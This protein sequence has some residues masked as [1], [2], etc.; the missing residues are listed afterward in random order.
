MKAIFIFLLLISSA[1]FAQSDGSGIKSH[2]YIEVYCIIKTSTS[3]YPKYEEAV[4]YYEGQTQFEVVLSLSNENGIT[5]IVLPEDFERHIILELKKKDDLKTP[6]ENLEIMDKGIVNKYKYK[7][8]ADYDR[9]NFKVLEP[10]TGMR[11]SLIGKLNNNRPLESGLY[12]LRCEFKEGSL[13]H[14]KSGYG[15]HRF[16]IV[17]PEMKDDL[18]A[19]YGAKGNQYFHANQPDKALE[20]Y[21]KAYELDPSNSDVYAG[22]GYAYLGLKDYRNAVIYLEKALSKELKGKSGLPGALARAYLATGEEKKALDTL[23][24]IMTED[25]AQR[26]LQE[27]R[28]QLRN[29]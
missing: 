8:A 7:E 19:Y 9:Q 2:P 22:L 11:A 25:D 23:R 24:L 1:A 16:R 12:E 29:Q 3:G 17:K 13:N 5:Q 10:G 26:S 4:V 27:L 28:I 21:Q 18:R 14:V 20:Y 15:G 6:K